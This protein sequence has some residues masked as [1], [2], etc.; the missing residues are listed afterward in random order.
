MR[1]GAQLRPG[2]P[3]GQL[4]A[5]ADVV[6][7]DEQRRL[8]RRARDLAR[9]RGE[10]VV[11]QQH[12]GVRGRARGRD[13]VAALGLEVRRGREPGEVGRAGRGDGRRLVRAP[14]AHL[15]ERAARPPR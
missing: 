4:D 2:R 13:A 14:R 8:R 10:L 5:A 9:E 3:H 6:G 15:D 12:E 11:V 1:I 7:V